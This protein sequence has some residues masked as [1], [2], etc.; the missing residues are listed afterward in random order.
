[1]AIRIHNSR[2]MSS[3]SR[4]ACERVPVTCSS[5][6][7]RRVSG[8]NS[9]RSNALGLRTYSSSVGRN[10]P[11]NQDPKGTGKPIFDLVKTASGTRG[12]RA[13]RRTS[14]VCHRFIRCAPGISIA[15]S[16]TWW[17]KYGTRLSSEAAMLI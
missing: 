2:L 11:R 9:P 10:A 5:T 16:T 3:H 15:C 8:L 12:R 1:M 6:S 17:S 13:S 14:F 7:L 4:S